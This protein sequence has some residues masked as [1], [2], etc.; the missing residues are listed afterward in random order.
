MLY[1]HDMLLLSGPII[2]VMD[3]VAVMFSYIF[4]EVHMGHREQG[5]DISYSNSMSI[6]QASLLAA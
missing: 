4:I 1:K 5:Y 3:C 6:N 2:V